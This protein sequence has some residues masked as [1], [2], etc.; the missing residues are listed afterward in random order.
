VPVSGRKSIKTGRNLP[1]ALAVGLI[2]GGL[3]LLTLLTVKV[4]FLILM[5][6]LVGVG[7]RELRSALASR[8]ISFR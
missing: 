3:V 7:L 1:A 5:A 6:A 8:Q 4:T 2:L